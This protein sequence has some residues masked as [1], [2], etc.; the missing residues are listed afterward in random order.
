MSLTLISGKGDVLKQTRTMNLNG[1]LVVDKPAGISSAKVVAIVKKALSA[2][3]VGHAGTLDP[4]ATGVLVCCINKATKLAQFFLQGKKKY[5]ALVHLGVETDTQD[6]TGNITSKT[7]QVQ[8]S[9][10]KIG[11]VFKRFEGKIEQLPPVFS[12]LKHKGVPLYKLARKGKPVQKPSRSVFISYIEILDINLP[13]V[14]LEVLC[15]SGT[16]VR[17]LCSD[18][19][20]SLG[21]GGHLKELRRTES[22]QFSIQDAISVPELEK[23]AKCGKLSQRLVNM[24]DALKDMKNFIANDDLTQKIFRGSIITPKDISPDLVK[25]QAGNDEDIFKVLDKENKLIA[26]LNF[27]TRKRNFKYN[28]VFNN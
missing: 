3:K 4:F 21:C 6:L 9:E 10:N 22:S 13:F 26:L 17:T 27:D 11:S 8:F 14:R 15:S 20:A 24:A 28:C 25:N 18:M 2:K 7:N 12:A 23:L 5:I 16:Y 19:G 1:I